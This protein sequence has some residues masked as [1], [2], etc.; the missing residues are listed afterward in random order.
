MTRGHVEITR[1]SS[2]MTSLAVAIFHDSGNQGA[3]RGRFQSVGSSSNAQSRSA[4]R[5]PPD[6]H[7]S[8]RSS[9]HLGHVWNFLEHRISIRR[10]PQVDLSK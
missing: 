9:S 1:S 4:A 3:L 2:A 8:H 5:S 7:D 10:P 6:G